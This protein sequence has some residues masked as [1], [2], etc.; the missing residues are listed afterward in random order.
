MGESEAA[1]CARLAIEH[2]TRIDRKNFIL[3]HNDELTAEQVNKI[4]AVIIE[5]KTGR[6]IQY[7]LKESWFYNLSFYVDD[8]VLIPRQETEELIQLILEPYD[9]EKPLKVLDIGTGSGC[10]PVALGHH[11]PEWKI[12]AIDVSKEALD[13]AVLNASKHQVPIHFQLVDVLNEQQTDDYFSKYGPFDIIISNPPYIGLDEK[14]TLPINVL[15]FEPHTALFASGKDVL[16]FYR[17][18]SELASQHLTE[19]GLLYYEIN[20]FKGDEMLQLMKKYNF[21]EVELIRDINNK[22]RMLRAVR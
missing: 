1:A 8:R 22:N 10:I 19:N 2:I 3:H 7:I 18:I 16:V 9:F 12:Y 5:L 21:E 20:E 4:N 14:K 15:N 17:R 6:P 11:K 13:V